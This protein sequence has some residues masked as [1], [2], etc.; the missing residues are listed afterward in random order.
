[1]YALDETGRQ[2]ISYTR[3]PLTGALTKT[4][5]GTSSR[6]S[7]LLKEAA[8]EAEKR[9]LYS[10]SVTA[11]AGWSKSDFEVPTR[12]GKRIFSRLFSP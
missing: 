8:I 7:T 4:D 5:H 1:M 6:S 2:H 12:D 3:D 9:R 11:G 10:G